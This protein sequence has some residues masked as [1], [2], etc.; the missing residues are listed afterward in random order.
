MAD[1]TGVVLG[2][3]ETLS[4]TCDSDLSEKAGYAVNLDVADERNVDL[5][6]DATLFPFPLIDG[7]D[8]SSDKKR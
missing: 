3:P 6:A 8:G 5:A 1:P 4:M 2:T 7:Y